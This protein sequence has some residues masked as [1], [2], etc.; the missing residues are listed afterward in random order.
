[1]RDLY[2]VILWEDAVKMFERDILP[3]IRQVE[4]R[5][6]SKSVDSCMRR[7][8]WN[9]WTDSLCKAGQISDWQ[10]EN[11]SHPDACEKEPRW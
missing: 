1:M 11:W 7:E 2:R 8:E 3:G 6:G 5:N 10:Y 9:N 4:R